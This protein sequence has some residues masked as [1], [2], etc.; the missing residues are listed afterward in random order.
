M[1][2]IQRNASLAL[3]AVLHGRSLAPVLD[4]IRLRSAR[5]QPNERAAIQD[6]AF[7]G[8]RWLGTLRAVLA[9]LLHAPLTDEEVEALLLITLYQLHWTR[10]APYAVVDSAVRTCTVLSKPAAKG[11]VNAVLRNFLRQR[12]ALLE[13][14]RATEVGRFSYPQWWIDE[15]RRAWPAQYA[16]ILDAGN[17]HPP[18]SL[19]VNRRRTEARSYLALLAQAGI[20][21]EPNGPVGLLLAKPV[22]V[23]VL[24]GFQEGLV[25]VQDLAA[26]CAAPLLDLA[27]GQRVLDAC[28]A[29]GGKSAHILELCDVELLALDR[30]VERLERVRGTLAR[31]GL[32]AQ[33][34]AADAADTARWWDGQRFERILLDAPCTASGVVRRHPDG[35]WLRRRADIAQ[36]AAEQSRLLEGLWHTLAADGKLLYVTCSVFPAETESRIAAFLAS[37]DDASRLALPGLPAGGQLRP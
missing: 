2:E 16:E 21:A 7:G 35:K 1:I 27:P 33:L 30:D 37:H 19:R 6:L 32:E 26:Q 12:E 9:Q 3:L 28:A 24:P 36:L 4:E 22:P 31:L 18:M 25:S 14:A 20:E 5:L 23:Q 10:A 17:L 29:P 13:R 11:L 8:C 15:V 34:Q